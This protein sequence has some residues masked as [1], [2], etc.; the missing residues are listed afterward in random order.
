MNYQH[1]VKFVAWDTNVLVV[2]EEHD[3]DATTL[4]SDPLIVENV[5][6]DRNAGP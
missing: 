5:C 1:D 2:A 3:D 4:M 6:L